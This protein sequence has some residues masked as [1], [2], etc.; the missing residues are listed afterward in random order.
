MRMDAWTKAYYMAG[1]RLARQKQNTG[2]GIL[3]KPLHEIW[4]DAKIAGH[5]DE[6]IAAGEKLALSSLSLE[7]VVLHVAGIYKDDDRKY[8]GRGQFPKIE[9][10]C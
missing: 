3:S 4:S 7:Y 2:F 8:I 9:V 10:R 6:S 5:V 1:N